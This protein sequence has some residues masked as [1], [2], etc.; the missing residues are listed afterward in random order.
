MKIRLSISIPASACRANLK[1]LASK[2]QQAC[3]AGHLKLDL[4]LQAHF[5]KQEF[6]AREREL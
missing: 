3:V 6:K 5:S 1:D 2:P 4:D